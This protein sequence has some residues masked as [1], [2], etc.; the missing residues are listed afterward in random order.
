[1]QVRAVPAGAVSQQGGSQGGA[2]HADAPGNQQQSR[3]AHGQA[4]KTHQLSDFMLLA[5][6][7]APVLLQQMPSA[8][9]DLV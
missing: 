6:D 9:S 4:N 1:M 5:Q 8:A 2:G 3:Q 7:E